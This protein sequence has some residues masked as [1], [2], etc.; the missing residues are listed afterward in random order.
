M[1]EFLFG[2]TNTVFAAA[3]TNAACWVELQVDGAVL[4]PRQPLASVPYSF[5][6]RNAVL[7]PAETAAGVGATAADQGAALGAEAVADTL[8]AAAGHSASAEFFGAA[9]GAEALAFNAGVAIGYQ[10][11][12][13]NQGV[14]VG[15]LAN[16]PSTN[17]A[18][19]VRA[20]ADGA[21]RAAIGYEITNLVDHSTAV[22]G[23]LY[24]DGGG[25]IR[26]RPT[27][28][29]GAWTVYPGGWTGTILVGAQTL[30]FTN[31]VLMNVTP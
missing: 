7:M 26:T 11:W 18:I 6:V 14:A 28:G 30:F 24:L 23:A 8:G 13:F 12:G 17:I 27:A 3:L 2:S 21:L 29:N 16:G 31:G 25:S 19:G 1:F 20:S 9:V 22:R 5:H 4:S 10:A 15:A